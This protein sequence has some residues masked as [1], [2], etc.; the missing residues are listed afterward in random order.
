MTTK[1]ISFDFDANEYKYLKMCCAKS[2]VK[3]REFI[4][5]AIIEAV[6]AKEDAWWLEMPETQELLKQSMEGKLDTIPLEDRLSVP[7][8]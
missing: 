7:Y 1:R 4:S 2:G 3:L 5:K 8:L 6:E